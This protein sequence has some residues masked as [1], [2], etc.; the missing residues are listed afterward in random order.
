MHETQKETVKTR[1]RSTGKNMVVNTKIVFQNQK[2][3]HVV[4]RLCH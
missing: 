3:C 1:E 4:Y 2:Q